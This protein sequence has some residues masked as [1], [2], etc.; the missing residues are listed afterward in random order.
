MASV[1]HEGR[2]ELEPPKM[3]ETDYPAPDEAMRPNDHD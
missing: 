1:L 3:I 2:G